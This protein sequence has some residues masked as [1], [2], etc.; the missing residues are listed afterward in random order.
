MAKKLIMKVVNHRH[1]SF[2]NCL[3]KGERQQN[4]NFL[5]CYFLFGNILIN[6]LI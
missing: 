2:M 4:Y 1:N 6:L 5:I 3:I